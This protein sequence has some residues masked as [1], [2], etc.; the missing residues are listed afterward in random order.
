MP[1]A[2]CDD[3]APSAVRLAPPGATAAPQVEGWSHRRP[4][5]VLPCIVKTGD[6]LLQEQFAMQLVR[7]FQDIFDAARLPLRL[8]AYAAYRPSP[9]TTSPHNLPACQPALPPPPP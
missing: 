7:A 2:L 4:A 5:G 3:T 1:S 6:A 8:H 9:L